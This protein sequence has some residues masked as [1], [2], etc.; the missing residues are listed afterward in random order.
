MFSFRIDYVAFC[1]SYTIDVGAFVG[2]VLVLLYANIVFLFH[3]FCLY[4]S[5]SSLAPAATATSTASTILFYSVVCAYGHLYICSRTFIYGLCYGQNY[6]TYSVLFTIHKAQINYTSDRRCICTYRTC[7]FRVAEHVRKNVPNRH[8]GYGFFIFFALQS[9]CSFFVLCTHILCFSC[10]L[11]SFRHHFD[12]F[13]FS[14]S[15]SSLLDSTRLDCIIAYL[16]SFISQ[17]FLLF[18]FVSVSIDTRVFS[19]V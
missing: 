13:F 4:V 15:L 2:F 10:A 19:V 17:F 3:C 14:L 18:I 11:R 12:R 5:L 6:F 7:I 8:H 16:F 1:T 9:L